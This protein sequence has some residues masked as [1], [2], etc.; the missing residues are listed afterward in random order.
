MILTWQTYNVQKLAQLVQIIL[1]FKKKNYVIL[2]LYS[3][4]I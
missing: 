3:T 2:K 4:S 1:H